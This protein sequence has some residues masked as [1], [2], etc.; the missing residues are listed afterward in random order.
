[1]DGDA[2]LY[3]A[4]GVDRNNDGDFDDANEHVGSMR[5]IQG[6]MLSGALTPGQLGIVREIRT[7]PAGNDVD[8]AVFT[9][10]RLDYFIEG[11]GTAGGIRDLDGDGFIRVTQINGGVVIGRGATDGFDLVRNVERLQFAD[12]TINIAETINQDPVGLAIISDTTPT[13]GQTITVDISGITDPNNTA[14]GGAITGPVSIVW[15]QLGDGGD[16]WVDVMTMDE[17]NGSQG[18]V[19]ATGPTLVV[20]WMQAGQPLRAK[21]TFLDQNG[22]QE[23]VYS[24]PTEPVIGINDAPIG[25][26]VISDPTPIEDE[27]LMATI[28]FSDPDGTTLAEYTYQWQRSLDGITW[29]NIADEAASSYLPT[30]ADVGMRLR[31]VVTYVDDLGTTEVVYSAATSPVANVNDAA[32]GTIAFSSAVVSEDVALVATPTNVQDPDGLP[33]PVAY[34]YQ[35]Y[36]SPTGLDGT[37]TAIAGATS[38]SYTPAQTQ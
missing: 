14:T 11:Q 8:T 20:G 21:I 37:F 28:A 7:A 16:V 1:I 35:W 9:S 25:S 5:A 4:I 3:V 17:G 34:T 2:Y 33:N 6:E 22:V 23:T 18:P 24:D 31:A 13:E 29:T 10:A 27:L 19:P 30:Q 36:A 12:Q 15:Q 32:T 26:L 38:A